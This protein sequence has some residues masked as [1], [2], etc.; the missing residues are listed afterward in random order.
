MTSTGQS[1][2]RRPL[3]PLITVVRRML[4]IAS[5]GWIA[6]WAA[7]A[8]AQTNDAIRIVE[9]VGTVEILPHGA[10]TWVLTQTRQELY[11]LDRIRVGTNSSVALLWSD[12]SVLRFGALTEL[13]ILPPQTSDADHGLHLIQGLLSFFHRDKLGRIRVIT[14]GALAGIE[15]TEFVMAVSTTNGV[16]QTTLSVIDGKVRFSNEQAVLVLT[17]DEQAVAEPGGAPQRTAG[18]IVNNL[19]QW[20]FYYPA[21]LDLKDL[22]LTTEEQK[23]LGDSLAAYREGDLLAAL[24][25]YPETREPDSDA[26]RVYHAALLLSVGQVAQAEAILSMLAGNGVSEKNQRLAS[27]LRTLI[28]A[29]K[30]EPNPSTLTPQLATE[31]LAASYYEQSLALRETSLVKALSLARQAV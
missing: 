7:P 22:S 3:K 30:R 8:S 6:H 24:A 13:E 23:I 25:K 21:V 27:A 18:F 19:L 10:T 5:L 17:N 1:G 14:S 26:G 28:A 4:L 12:Q 29:V 31:L 2:K 9:L 16:E 11:A 15:G 20:C